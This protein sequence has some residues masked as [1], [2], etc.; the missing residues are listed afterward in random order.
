MVIHAMVVSGGRLVLATGNDGTVHY[1]TPDGTRS[2]RLVDTEAAQVACLAA[3]ADGSV[4]FGTADAG[5]VGRIA[6]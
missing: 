1:V 3:E 2:G 4:V 6:A 5:S